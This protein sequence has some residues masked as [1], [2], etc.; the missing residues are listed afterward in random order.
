[1]KAM[2]LAAGRGERMR[3]LTDYTA[4]PLLTADGTS[5]IDF[6]LNRLAV[7][8]ITEVVINTCWQAEKIAGHVGDGEKYGLSV[9]YSHE[10]TA[11]ETAGGIA[12]AMPLLG[13]DP[14]LL[15]STDVWSESEF[16]KST[17]LGKTDLAHLVMVDN[18]PHHP[19]GDFT[20]EQS[21]V[22]KSHVGTLTYSGIGIFRPDMFRPA[23]NRIM[24]LR[25]VLI[26]AIKANKVS[27]QHYRGNWMDIGTPER[28]FT[29]EKLLKNSINR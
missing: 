24:P 3:P 11:L 4:K 10:S 25:E 9:E 16:P 12:N 28:L 13:C 14:F 21:R 15:I 5:L 27:G 20:L 2:L 19:S 17:S 18:P 1:M 29:L 8:G 23:V 26:P 6:H 7:S 22:K